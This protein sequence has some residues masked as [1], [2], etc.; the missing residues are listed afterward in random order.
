MRLSFTLASFLLAATSVA[1]AYYD[2]YL[3]ARGYDP[4]EAR[5]SYDVELYERDYVPTDIYARDY[6][7]QYFARDVS[8]PDLELRDILGDVVEE[9]VR[10]GVTKSKKISKAS[11]KKPA[12]SRHRPSPKIKA[13]AGPPKH[14]PVAWRGKATADLKHPL[15][16][17][18]KHGEDAKKKHE[19]IV[20]DH[21]KTHVTS[22]HG[23]Q[24]FRAAHPGGFN[25]TEK[26][27]ITTKYFDH[28][29]KKIHD[30]AGHDL[31]HVYTG[32]EK[33]TDL[34]KLHGPSS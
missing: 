17:T 6:D 19:E 23:A 10:R 33:D 34:S 2:D 21:A 32:R 20:R 4:L 16:S 12:A 5:S 18:W 28:K 27:H 3:Y 8:A 29:G 25:P 11:S 31:H 22:A 30:A 1:S 14:I 15:A 7:V 13:P 24:I 9:L 26:D